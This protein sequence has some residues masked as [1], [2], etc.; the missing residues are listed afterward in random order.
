MTKKSIP[1]AIIGTSV[2][3]IKETLTV[4]FELQESEG[5]E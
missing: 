5:E 4:V 3:W 2:V 1:F